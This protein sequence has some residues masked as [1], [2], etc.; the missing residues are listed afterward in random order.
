MTWSVLHT[1]GIIAYAASGAFVAMQAKYSFIGIFVLGLT[2]SY[3]GSVIRNVVLDEPISDIWDRQSLLIV[4]ITLTTIIFVERKWVHHWKRWG[5]FF[6]S[7]GLASFAIQGALLAESLQHDLGIIVIASMFTGVGGGMVR[8]LLA[9]RTPLALKE[10][11]H[12]ILTF[13]CAIGIW[14][15]WSSPIELSTI[16]VIVVFIRML[17]VHCK[18]R[19]K[20][21]CNRSENNNNSV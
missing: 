5:Y 19:L 4:L 12:A 11:I 8:D 13:L 17:S 1:I 6:D 10:E 21:P 15:G 3:G 16:V 2:T 18:W 7:I 9:G 20:L 14:A